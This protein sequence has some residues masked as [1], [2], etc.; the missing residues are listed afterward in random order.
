[1][2]SSF[3]TTQKEEVVTQKEVNIRKLLNIIGLFIFSGI[4]LTY[5]TT[6]LPKT[7]CTKEYLYFL[8]GG[9]ITYYVLLN[10][11]HIGHTGRKVVLITLFL[12]GCFSI[13]MAY[14]SLN[15]P[16]SHCY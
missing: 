8:V 9:A 14:Y 1:M 3:Q 6:S 11:Y 5:L 13:F 16:V 4:A 10:I 7:D 15:N 2:K 12:L